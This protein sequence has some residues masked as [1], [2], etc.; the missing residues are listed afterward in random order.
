MFKDVLMG[1]PKRDLVGMTVSVLK[2]FGL[3]LSKSDEV[4][5]AGDPTSLAGDNIL[6]FTV[7][8]RIWLGATDE[9]TEGLFLYPDGCP[10]MWTIWDSN[11]PNE[12]FNQNCID[13][14]PSGNWQDRQCSANRYYYCERGL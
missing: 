5:F 6:R 8:F 2:F 14:Q 4:V 10:L 9:E 3:G 13:R 12:N 11:Q 1:I 7:C